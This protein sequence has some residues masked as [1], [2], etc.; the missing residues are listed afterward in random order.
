M[1]VV[2]F[3][4]LALTGLDASPQQPPP[5]IL[6]RWDLTIQTPDGER[7]AWLEVRH[8]GVRTLVG[9]F[10]G[11]SGSARPISEVDFK[12][13]EMRFAIPPQWERV[14]GNIS[15]TGRLDGERLTGALTLGSRTPL[16]WTGVRAPSLRRTTAPRWDAPVSLFNGRDLTGWHALGTNEWEAVGGVLRNRKS[17]GNL[18]T[19]QTFDDFRLH[20]EFRYPASGNSG[21]YLRGRYEVQIADTPGAEPANDSLGAVYG[22]LTPAEMAA[23]KPGEWQS[24][25]VTLTG[26]MVTVVLNGR[27]I[28]ANQEI[29]GIT[30]AALDS[31]EGAPGP[32]LLQGDHGPIEFRN[33][34]LARGR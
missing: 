4:L 3:I 16:K 29:P 7:S 30:G 33:L 21:V 11:M 27:T 23:R 31:R 14:E 34:T 26:R 32:L 20:A 8:S 12:D 17:G 1:T 5:A 13:G 15:V 6:G 9:Q 19:D 25:D 18:V 2:L 24:F 10:V 28:I 22:F